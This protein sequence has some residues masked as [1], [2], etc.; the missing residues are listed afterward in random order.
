MEECC[1][2][3]HLSSF[4][5][6]QRH[7]RGEIKLWLTFFFFSLSLVQSA[8]KIALTWVHNT[9]MQTAGYICT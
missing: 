4:N 8:S 1:Y 5:R 2:C 7:C 9:L 6:H 3:L